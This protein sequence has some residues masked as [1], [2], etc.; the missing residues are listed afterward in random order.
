MYPTGNLFLYKNHQMYIIYYSND[1]LFCLNCLNEFFCI[2]ILEIKDFLKKPAPL[3]HEV[4]CES[5]KQKR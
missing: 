3:P 1:G 5:V 2:S 4:R